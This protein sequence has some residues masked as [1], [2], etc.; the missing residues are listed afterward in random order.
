MKHVLKK[1]ALAAACVAG[2]LETPATAQTFLEKPLSIVVTFSAGAPT[3]VIARVVAEKLAARIGRPVVI[4]NRVGAAGIIG[5][6]YVAKAPADG[7]TLLFTP[8]SVAFANLVVKSGGASYDPVRDL[9]P[10]IDIGNSP[11]FLYASPSSGFKTFQ[12]AVNGARGKNLAYGSAGT[13]S[14]LHIIGEAVNKATNINLLHVPYKGVAP[15]VADVMA[16]HVPFTYAALLKPQIDTGKLV[17]LVV[18]GRARTRLAPEV[19][20]LQE[21]GYKVDLDSWYG[22]FG[23]RGMSP[24]MVKGLNEHLNEILKMPDVIERMATFGATPGGGAPEVLGKINAADV[25]RIGRIIKDLQIQ[26]D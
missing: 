23:P 2:L 6:S 17:P 21:L 13:G 3:D 9:T 8:S 26:A 24:E 20:T 7:H 18:T 5:T 16:G 4:D 25:E 10:I 11:I 15:A 12:E 19:P 1:F 22:I 14:I